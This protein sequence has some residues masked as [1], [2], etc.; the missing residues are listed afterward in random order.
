[1]TIPSPNASKALYQYYCKFDAANTLA[2]DTQARQVPEAGSAAWSG[3]AVFHPDENTLQR[4][5]DD[6][7]VQ[8]LG[9]VALDQM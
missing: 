3:K 7:S 8:V 6:S 9:Y 4:A 5:E 1:M 2:R